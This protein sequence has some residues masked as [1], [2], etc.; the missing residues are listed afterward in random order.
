MT[1]IW[2]KWLMNRACWRLTTEPLQSMSSPGAPP[3]RESSS[4]LAK[5]PNRICTLLLTRRHRRRGQRWS[6][7]VVRRSEAEKLLRWKRQCRYGNASRELER[8]RALE[9]FR[10]PTKMMRKDRGGQ[11]WA[12]SDGPRQ[13]RRFTEESSTW[14]RRK[15]MGGRRNFCEF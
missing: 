4:A 14:G 9:W 1:V 8:A 6:D 13:R 15:G 11:S 10:E 3:V 5:D 2:L 7:V 12:G